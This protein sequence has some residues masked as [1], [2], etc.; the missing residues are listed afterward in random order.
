MEEET[1]F[2]DQELLEAADGE[3]SASQAARIDRHLS[4]CWT[5]RARKQELENAMASFVHVYHEEYDGEIP[6][7]D[8]P[9]AMLR[10]QMSQL[11]HKPA[12]SWRLHAMAARGE[13]EPSRP[14]LCAGWP[15]RSLRGS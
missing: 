12:S 13:P 5:C 3:V 2:S 15:S 10:A 6:P 7:A 1:H 4:R 8:G 11:A 14:S 9:R